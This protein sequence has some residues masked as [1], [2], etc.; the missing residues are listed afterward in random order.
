MLSMREQGTI[1]CCTWK[2]DGASVLALVLPPPNRLPQDHGGWNAH[3]LLPHLHCRENPEVLLGQIA[4]HIYVKF[5]RLP[6][7]GGGG[8]RGGGKWEAGCCLHNAACGQRRTHC[9]ALWTGLSACSHEPGSSGAAPRTMTAHHCSCPSFQ[10]SS[11][12]CQ[13]LLARQA[14]PRPSPDKRWQLRRRSRS[15][16]CC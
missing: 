13:Q 8:G 15:R 3:I 5:L 2:Q 16:T 7:A 12:R 9:S 11:T 14:P 6:G 10:W 4:Q 1:S